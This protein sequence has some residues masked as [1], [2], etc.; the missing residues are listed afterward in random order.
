[1]EG[2]FKQQMGEKKLKKRRWK[3]KRKKQH[4][5][6]FRKISDVKWV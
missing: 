2:N 4:L 3:P 1:M 5:I 6:A